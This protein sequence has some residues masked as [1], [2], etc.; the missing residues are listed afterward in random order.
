MT[1]YN[2]RMDDAVVKLLKKEKLKSSLWLSI[3]DNL[4]LTIH[5]WH[6]HKEF[7]IRLYSALRAQ[8]SQ[9]MGV[10]KECPVEHA[11]NEDKLRKIVI[12]IDNLSIN[13]FWYSQ[14]CSVLPEI[15]E[16]GIYFEKSCNFRDR[17]TRYLF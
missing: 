11:G 4:S 12:R 8:V 7:D 17:I 14:S 5:V 1:L 15:V 6:S 2:V 3:L 9:P 16:K 13:E 10:L